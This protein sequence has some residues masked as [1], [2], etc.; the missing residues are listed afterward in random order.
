MHYLR[1]SLTETN[2]LD[3]RRDGRAV[4]VAWEGTLDEP[5]VDAILA[6]MVG[7]DPFSVVL[8]L[9]RS[10]SI[11]DSAL[12]QLARSLRPEQF[13]GLREHQVRLLRYLEKKDLR[14]APTDTSPL[15]ELEN[16]V[17]D[18]TDQFCKVFDEERD[19]HGGFATAVARGSLPHGVDPHDPRVVE[20]RRKCQQRVASD[21]EAPFTD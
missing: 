17:K 16:I 8:D 1:M 7:E 13:R 21:S 19:F 14:E 2:M 5:A 20:I 3:V 4:I 18:A 15:E 10:F 12:A 9:T 6:A 11:Q